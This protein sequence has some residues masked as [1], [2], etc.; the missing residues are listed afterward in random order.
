MSGLHAQQPARPLVIAHR[1][2]SGIAPEN[3]LA[4]IRKAMETGV[5]MIE[6]DVH[7]TRDMQVVVVHDYTIDRTTNGSGKIKN[8][9]FSQI[10]AFDAGRW[11]SAEYAG[12]R[13]PSLDEVLSLVN[14]R[15]KLLIEIKP[16]RTNDKHTEMKVLESIR[17]HHAQ[18]WCIIQSFSP[19]VLQ[20]MRMLDPVVEL[21]QLVVGDVPLL[22]LH[23]HQTLAGGSFTQYRHV[24]AV[25]PN[26]RFA[27]KRKINKLHKR[28]QRILVWTVD[29]PQVMEDMIA[30]GVDGIITNHPERL[31]NILRTKGLM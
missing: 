14:G 10:R 3:T 11:F 18:F 29:D 23:Y 25:N 1:G 30:K 24:S 28:G 5:N 4:A 13:I 21:H 12:E 31:I 26:H 19:K 20:N 15:H 16:S 27:S 17:S 22:P 8:L 9:D 6:I 7:L 2:A